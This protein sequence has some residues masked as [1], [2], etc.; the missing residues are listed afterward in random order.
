MIAL[1]IAHNHAWAY[2]VAFTALVVSMVA[3][4]VLGRMRGRS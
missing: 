4:I 2:V 3:Y 1:L